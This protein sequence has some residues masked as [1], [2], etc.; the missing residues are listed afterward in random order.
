MVNQ[1]SPIKKQIS[2][3]CELDTLCPEHLLHHADR[4]NYSCNSKTSMIFS[5]KVTKT[6]NEPLDNNTGNILQ[7]CNCTGVKLCGPLR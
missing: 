3:S 4:L 7:F 1:I 6:E 5:Y 2:M